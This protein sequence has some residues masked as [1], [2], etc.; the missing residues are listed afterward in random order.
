MEV[1]N[2][3][4]LLNEVWGVACDEGLAEF[5]IGSVCGEASEEIVAKGRELLALCDPHVDVVTPIK[6]GVVRAIE[7]ICFG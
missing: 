5:P 2:V 4:Q 1:T 3:K 6:T 7:I